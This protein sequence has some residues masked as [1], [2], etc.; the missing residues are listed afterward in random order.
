MKESRKDWGAQESKK[1]NQ[2]PK[3]MDPQL[4]EK[5]YSISKLSSRISERLKN[6]SMALEKHRV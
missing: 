1:E 3:K 2:V 6:M 5:L 4:A